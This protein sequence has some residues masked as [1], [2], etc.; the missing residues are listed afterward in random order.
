MGRK[1]ELIEL[2]ADGAVHSGADLAR[3]LRC[4]RTT[5]WKQLHQLRAKGLEIT[6]APGR[7]YALRQP[8]ELLDRT[9]ILEQLDTATIWESLDVYAVTDS[10]SER[11]RSMQAPAPGNMR[12][13]LAEYQTG[14]RGRRG[15]PWVSPYGSGLCLSTSWCFPIVPETLP[16]LSLAAGVAV[17]RVLARFE[18]IELGLKWP[19]DVVA[20]SGK[21]GGLLVDVQ[22]E[23]GG[24]LTVV[25]GVGIN[26]DVS[27][28]MR[29]GLSG[30]AGLPPVALRDL[31]TGHRVSR[32]ALAADIIK[33]LHIMLSDFG[34]SGF[35]SF[36]DEWRHYDC[37]YG[38]QV[39]VEIG[40]QTCTGIASGIDPTGALLLDENGTIRSV[41]SGEVTLR[42]S[43]CV[44]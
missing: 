23:S 14:G 39:E 26:V 37:M 44:S 12:V 38:R 21:L 19:N 30:L 22:G 20:G 43:T 11:L 41:L 31:V 16:A 15:R 36:A 27:K 13:V 34:D 33:E 5:V 3:V 25:V 18:P 1:E 17:C 24:P 29:D 35:T 7:G 2:L 32:N 40:S 10:T 9:T 6:G 42:A 4:S 28:P 8:L